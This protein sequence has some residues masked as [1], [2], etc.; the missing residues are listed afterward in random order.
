MDAL[1]LLLMLA[2]FFGL[3][4]FA[5]DRHLC[6]KEVAADL[7]IAHGDA[8]VARDITDDPAIKVHYQAT[9]SVYKNLIRKHFG[10]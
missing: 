9:A 1:V 2:G 8:L 4:I 5:I 10:E 6:L 3:A 7:K